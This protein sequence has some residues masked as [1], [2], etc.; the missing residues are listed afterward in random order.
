MGTVISVR[1]F[2]TGFSPLS[3]FLTLFDRNGCSA[4]SL[5]VLLV[6]LHFAGV[7]QVVLVSVL[8]GG[9][10]PFADR[11]HHLILEFV[12]GQG[13]GLVVAGFAAFAVVLIPTAKH[14]TPSVYT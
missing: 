2:I 8:L 7:R 12:P 14:K 11:L 9:R 4:L 1:P 6:F 3:T 13:P 10:L 5:F